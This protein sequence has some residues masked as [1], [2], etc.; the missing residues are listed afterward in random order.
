[1]YVILKKVTCSNSLIFLFCCKGGNSSGYKKF[2]EEEGMVDETYNENLV[3]LFRVQGISPEN[4]QAIQIDQ[5]WFNDSYIFIHGGALCIF[6][7]SY[8]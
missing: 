6:I 5:V 3:A 7:I 1:M 4:M 2:I 8:L